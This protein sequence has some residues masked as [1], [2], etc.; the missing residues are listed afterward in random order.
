MTL[1]KTKIIEIEK[2][3]AKEISKHANKDIVEIDKGH[4]YP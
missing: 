2:T 4:L 1:G 3:T